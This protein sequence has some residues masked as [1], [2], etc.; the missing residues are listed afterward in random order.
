[1]YNLLNLDE[2]DI[3]L[4]KKEGGGLWI[5]PKNSW[6]KL[7]GIHIFHKIS[8]S[9]IGFNLFYYFRNHM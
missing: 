9:T 6:L 3:G 4:T 7:I 5:F 8:Q 1:M 2:K